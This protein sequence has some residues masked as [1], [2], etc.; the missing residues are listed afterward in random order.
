MCRGQGGDGVGELYV[1]L[2]KSRFYQFECILLQVHEVKMMLI[3]CQRLKD[4]IITIW[5]PVIFR[6]T[7]WFCCHKFHI[8]ESSATY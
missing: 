8:G 2:M 7:A 3:V 4:K 6:A 1:Q 5:V